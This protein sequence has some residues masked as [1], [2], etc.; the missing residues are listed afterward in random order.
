M[1]LRSLFSARTS[2]DPDAIDNIC[3]KKLQENKSHLLNLLQEDLNTHPILKS[4]SEKSK[5]QLLEN[6]D[7]TLQIT[8]SRKESSDL[9]I[10]HWEQLKNQLINNTIML[11]TR[12]EKDMPLLKD[13][14]L[15]GISNPKLTDLIFTD[16]DPHKRGKTVVILEFTGDD[17]KKRRVVYKPS[18]VQTDAM[19]VGN[20]SKLSLVDPEY[21]KNMSM[22]EIFNQYADHK[23][24][25]YMVLPRK[26]N[27]SSIDIDNH[28]GYVEFIQQNP[29]LKF[30]LDDLNDVDKSQ[31]Q[32]VI[33]R[34]IADHLLAGLNVDNCD[35]ILRTQEQCERYSYVCGLTT[36][37]ILAV[38]AVDMHHENMIIA[39]G[40]P[41]L[42]DLECGLH[43]EAALDVTDTSLI[44]G[45]KAAFS[46]ASRRDAYPPG[47]EQ[48]A[49]EMVIVG[50][51]N[52]VYY[53]DAQHQVLKAFPPEK[54]AFIR[55][56]RKGIEIIAMRA[57]KDKKTVL[58][59]F[60]QKQTAQML[61]RYIP[62]NT[63]DWARLLNRQIQSDYSPSV[64]QDQILA[65]LKKDLPNLTIN[66]KGLYE[67][68]AA[69][70]I[71]WFY[72]Q[73]N[74]KDLYDFNSEAIRPNNQAF[75]STAPLQRS[76]QNCLSIQTEYKSRGHRDKITKIENDCQSS[77]SSVES[78]S[79]Q[80][81]LIDAS[82]FTQYAKTIKTIQD[83]LPAKEEQEKNVK[84]FIAEA[85]ELIKQYPEPNEY[86]GMVY[87]HL[88]VKSLVDKHAMVGGEFTLLDAHDL[89]NAVED[90]LSNVKDLPSLRVELL[91]KMLALSEKYHIHEMEMTKR[92]VEKDLDKAYDKLHKRLEKA[93]SKQNKDFTSYY[94][95]EHH[96]AT[97]KVLMRCPGKV[98]GEAMTLQDAVME[99][100]GLNNYQADAIKESILR[101]EKQLLELQNKL[102]LA[103]AGRKPAIKNEIDQLLNKRLRREDVLGLNK[104]AVDTLVELHSLGVKADDLRKIPT[105][106]WGHKDALIYLIR[107]KKTP[108][109]EAVSLL[110]RI[111]DAV[112]AMG[113]SAGLTFKEVK[114][115]SNEQISAYCHLKESGLTVEH[116][117]RLQASKF[118]D[119]NEFS[120]FA[121]LHYNALKFLI[122]TCNLA[123]EQAIDEINYLN[124][125][126]VYALTTLYQYGLRGEHLQKLWR[127]DEF[128][129]EHR[130]NLMM[131]MVN[132]NKKPEQAIE[133]LCTSNS[134]RPGRLGSR[135]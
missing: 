4:L 129:G 115:L 78:S 117:L 27:N 6:L 108:I 76:Q 77:L 49:E 80:L 44:S 55:G 65:T 34:A 31:R 85:A 130:V 96:G 133:M 38:G 97:I 32:L 92:Q 132:E 24:P 82:F 37:M 50:E 79:T 68:L 58:E 51:K 29:P 60:S 20:T 54:E 84:D 3:R 5:T 75:F 112:Q 87:L 101:L 48:K 74:G 95:A 10:K 110:G 67:E 126:Q 8:P 106:S 63:S 72:V 88:R 12:V 22:A 56:L 36:A 40:L 43:P 13:A 70:S 103:P 52:L 16:S 26:D 81:P 15:S 104:E 28:Y 118:P 19:I 33:D 21:K 122:K 14:F 23:I 2:K 131:L 107:D 66:E 86:P 102:I 61:A 99:V 53:Y 64:F 83:R 134:P 18:Q 111:Q 113:I 127:L 17:Q 124:K 30:S 123:P 59:W 114:A 35:F 71:P 1:F 109:E 93:Y 69:H 47:S 46:P 62:Y 121:D 39:K 105:F 9:I 128:T 116:L 91:K 119:G 120:E 11:L 57:N 73:V 7:R 135:D 94:W 90:E 125:Q 100:S 45:E 25:T 89:A 42:I 41:F 98:L